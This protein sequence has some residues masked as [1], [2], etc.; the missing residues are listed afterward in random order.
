VSP[1]M[2]TPELIL[3]HVHG[4]WGSAVLATSI[5]QNVFEHLEQ[6]GCNAERLAERLAVPRRS[7]QAILDGLLAMELVANDGGRYRNT[8]TASKYLV[9]GKPDYVG[10]YATMI[11]S[12][13]RSWETFSVSVITGKPFQVQERANP[14]NA[15]WEELVPAIGP[16]AMISARATAERLDIAARPAFDMLDIAGGSGAFCAVWLR[17]NHQA[18]ATQIDWP[19]VN[20]IAQRYVAKFGVEER[21]QT[22]DGDMERLEF[23]RSAYDYIIYASVAHG[24]SPERNVA[25][26]ERI[27]A[28]LKPNGCFVIVGT[29]PNEDRTGHPLVLLFNANMLL[30]TEQGMTYVR[31]DYS[32][33]LASAGFSQVE[34]QTLDEMPYTVIY[35]K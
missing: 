1:N 6:D 2:L 14:N 25:M 5:K 20:A 26:F 10:G 18:R 8:P 34:Y 33:W 13:W 7:T 17:L 19:N 11:L 21:F 3:K 22:L 23:G 28:A 15:F 32:H 12:T 27:R 9:Q 4:F 35:A 16:L 24:L 29:I 30:N 31:S